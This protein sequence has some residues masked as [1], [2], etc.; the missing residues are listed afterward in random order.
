LLYT[1]PLKPKPIIN[2][3]RKVKHYTCGSTGAYEKHKLLMVGNWRLRSAKENFLEKLKE[4][5]MD[6]KVILKEGV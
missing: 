3:L 5:K 2:F 6:D 4:E 1:K